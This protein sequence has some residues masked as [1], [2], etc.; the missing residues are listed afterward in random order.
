[1][2][3]L[4]LKSKQDIS[5]SGKLLVNINLFHKRFLGFNQGGTNVTK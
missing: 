3:G 1:M 2:G 5:L 4:T